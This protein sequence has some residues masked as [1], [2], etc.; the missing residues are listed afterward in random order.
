[1]LSRSV[2][3]EAKLTKLSR[4]N[5]DEEK[6]PLIE[7]CFARSICFHALHYVAQP[8]GIITIFLVT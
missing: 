2:R 8:F 5:S 3:S 4:P 6:T 1:M 7:G